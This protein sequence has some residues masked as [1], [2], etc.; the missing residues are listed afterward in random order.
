L[1]DFVDLAKKSGWGIETTIARWDPAIAAKL[2]PEGTPEA[3]ISN[4]LLIY[5][6]LEGMTPALA[7]EERLWTRLCHVEC[8][9]YTRQRWL[10]EKADIKSSVKS[11]FFAGGVEGCRDDNAIGRLWWNGH[12]ASLG[13]PDNIELGL[14]RLL[15]RA[16]TRLQIIDRADTA[17]R[18]PLIMGIF[19]LLGLDT[20]LKTNDAAVA[21]FMFEVNKRSGG[22]V[23]EA[24]T[25]SEVDAHLAECLVFAKARRPPP[26]KA[27]A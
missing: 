7:R 23:F 11:H 15:G 4:S 2:N 26:T 3:E 10:R 22:I 25:D 17:F 24:L 27:A 13:C 6:G 12:V 9:E 18:Q 16:N 19:R 20:W 5:Q 8:L 21:D 1:G 14:S